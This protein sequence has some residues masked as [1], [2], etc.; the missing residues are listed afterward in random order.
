MVIVLAPLSKQK[1]EENSAITI[2]TQYKPDVCAWKIVH[3]L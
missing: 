1:G 2:F 3:T